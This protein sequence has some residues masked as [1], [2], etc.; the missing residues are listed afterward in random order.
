[1]LPTL[2][3]R[4]VLDLVSH[5]SRTALVLPTGSHL[6]HAALAERVAERAQSWG[7]G[8]RLVLVEGANQLEAVISYLAAL[9]HGHVALVVPDGRGDQTDALI[10]HYDPDIVCGSGG[11]Q[12]RRPSSAHVLHPDLALLLSTSGSTGSPKLV[13]LSRDNVASNAASI[14]D[15]LGLGP[16]DRAMTTLPLHYCYG[17]SVLHSHLHAGASLVLTDGSVV[18]PCFWRLFDDAAATSFA[19]VPYTFEMLERSGFSERDHPTLRQVTQAGGRLAPE[20]VR[21]W[22]ERGA[23]AGWDFVVMYGQTEATARMAWLPPHLARA[24]PAAIGVPVPGGQLRVD[25]V[26]EVDTPG[27]GEL[28][29]TGPNVMMGYATCSADLA[30]GPELHELRTGDLGRFS[31]GLYEVVGRRN[32]MA[33]VFGLRLDLDSLEKSLEQRHTPAHCLA[34][35]ERVHAFVEHPEQAADVG[36][37]VASFCG[38][39]PSAVRVHTTPAVPRTDSGKVDHT[40]LLALARESADPACRAE[41]ADVADPL[42]VVCHEYAVVLGH[43]EPQGSD[44]FVSLGGDSLSYVELATRLDPLLPDGLPVAWHLRTISSLAA[45]LPGSTAPGEPTGNVPASTAQRRRLP[46]LDT[47]IALRALAIVLIVASHVDLVDVQGGAHLLL[48]LAGYN[49]ARFQLGVDDRAARVR[50]GVAGLAQLAVPSVIWIAGVGVVLGTYDPATAVFLN[51]VLG[52][53]TWTDQWQFWFLEALVWTTAAVLALMAVPAVHAAERR[54]PFAFP[55]VLLVAAGGLRFAQVGVTAGPTERYTVGVVAFF[56]VLGWLGARA[57][58]TRRR[59]LVSVAALVLVLDFFDQPGREAVVLLG[60]VLTLWVPRLP[61]PRPLARAAMTL[62]GASLF[63]YLTQW[64]VYPPL[65]DA[66]HP[67]AAMLAAFAVGIAYGAV[68]RPVQR[69]LASRLTGRLTARRDAGPARRRPIGLPSDLAGGATAQSP[70]PRRH[71]TV[72]RH[73]IDNWRAPRAPHVR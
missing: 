10:A 18:D 44:T 9:N 11:T 40:A 56:F 47:T 34:L 16:D 60:L 21:T 30:R 2:D 31:D 69:R 72:K 25:P 54:H 71:T 39:A 45:L 33:K 26:P 6:S 36:A 46:M 55:L 51:G 42:S 67:V 66:G 24:H 7:S 13:R 63:I 58:T 53:D 35:D 14:A 43:P 27:V 37:A 15:Y 23:A 68:M 73:T 4:P 29:Y 28:V 65:E 22:A 57:T 12:I 59:V 19:G 64:Q 17:L 49:F 1:M 3:T 70:N 8:R 61:C 48:V 52:S 50:H 32:R 20:R 62:A 41:A 38:I 5:G